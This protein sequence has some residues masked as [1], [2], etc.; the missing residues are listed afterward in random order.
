MLSMHNNSSHLL[1]NPLGGA[2]GG[3]NTNVG[4]SQSTNSGGDGGGS[5]IQNGVGQK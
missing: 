2:S 5:L 1:I 3:I 4:N